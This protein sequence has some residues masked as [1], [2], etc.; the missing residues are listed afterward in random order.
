MKRLI[1]TSDDFGVATAVNE[2]V[3]QAHTRGI[4]TAASLMVAGDA[5]ADAVARAKRLPTL[6]VGLHLVLV[7]GRPMLPAAQ[8]PDLVDATGHFRTNMVLAGVNFFFRP[9]VRRQLAAEIKAQFAAFAATGLPLDHVNAHKHFHLHPTIA[10]LILS[11]GRRYGLA[12]ARAPVE[13][14]DMIAAIEPVPQTLADRIAAP[15]ARGVAR[16]FRAAGLV[17]PDRVL[18][19][20]WSGHMTTERVRALIAAL[21]PGLTEL[22]CH[23]ATKDAYPGSAPGYAYRAELAALL[24]PGVRALVAERDIH[25]G[26]FADVT[27]K[28][29]LAA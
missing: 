4:L 20:A 19:L 9:S 5:A 8:V 12:A 28:E 27:R 7:E 29:G 22:Y 2:A 25:L 6:G 3:E 1:V 11:I 16:R 15:Y 17:V 23:P 24:D 21:P 26:R 10:G 13:P 14:M 18:G